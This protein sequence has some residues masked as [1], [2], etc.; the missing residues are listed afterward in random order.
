[1]HHLLLSN[2]ITCQIYTVISSFPL[3]LLAANPL[4][5]KVKIVDLGNAC[6]VVSSKADT[7]MCHFSFTRIIISLRIFRLDSIAV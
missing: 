6:W 4:D 3:C 5:L 7:S 1:M 2:V